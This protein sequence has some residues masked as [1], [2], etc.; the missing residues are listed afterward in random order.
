[1][2]TLKSE[3]DTDSI[4][5]DDLDPSQIAAR[6]KERLNAFEDRGFFVRDILNI[7]DR[8]VVLVATKLPS[9][10]EEAKPATPEGD[11]PAGFAQML[12]EAI[13]NGKAKLVDITP[14]AIPVNLED[15]PP[16]SAN[17]KT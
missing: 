14:A 2:T 17:L 9:L 6:L 15:G 12:L 5:Y 4:S 10:L 8:G 13:Q 3:H 1:M 11:P 7:H 16:W